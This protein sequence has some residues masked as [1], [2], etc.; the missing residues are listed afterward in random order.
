MSTAESSQS[1]IIVEGRA[2]L[3]FTGADHVF[4]N[5][6]MSLN[7]DIGVLL[8]KSYFDNRNIMICDP[9]T[10]SGVRA[11]RYLLECSNVE[12]A[13]ASDVDP[14]A[15]QFASQMVQLNQLSDLVSVVNSNANILLSNNEPR[16]DFVDLDP[17]GSPAPFFENG[18]RATIDGGI[19]A[20][21][22]TDMAPLTG[23]RPIACFRK[24]GIHPLRTEF[25]KEV[26]IR[27]LMA[28]LSL[29]SV[30]L[31]LGL[32]LVFSHASDHYA[33]VYVRIMKGRG[34]AN[35]T[36]RHLS[37]VEYCPECLNR[38]F[39][40]SIEDLEVECNNCHVNK[41]IGG[42]IWSDQLWDPRLV[43]KMTSN[44]G[45]IISNRMS[46]V[47][48]LLSRI[49]DEVEAPAFYYRTDRIAQKLHMN[50]PKTATVVRTL[51]DKGYTATLTHFDPNGFR[52]NAAARI[53]NSTV[54]QLTKKA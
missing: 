24:Y 28:C 17:F 23:A 50:P 5:P 2:N 14:A 46:E 43:E 36:I 42:P 8:V 47:Q 51:R 31:E 3:R 15:V 7:R 20:A 26:A 10:A 53:I 22:A 16:F 32:R 1:R 13:T 38:T 41:K 18:L 29:T 27:I 52:T 19:L 33:R 9:M 45:L 44:A 11:I 21:T 54:S 30:R 37:Y 48:N 40:G 4:Y 6:K 39:R 49:T 25:G 12:G 34:H 35:E